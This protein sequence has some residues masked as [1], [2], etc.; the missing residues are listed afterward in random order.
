VRQAKLAHPRH[1]EQAD[2]VGDYD[3]GFGQARG[4]DGTDGAAAVRYDSRK[5]CAERFGGA[6]CVGSPRAR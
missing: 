2:A 5:R 6:V 4:V 1:I 3:H